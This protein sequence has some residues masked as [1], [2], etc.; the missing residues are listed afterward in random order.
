MIASGPIESITIDG[1][2][3]ATDGEDDVGIQLPGFT[4]EVKPNGDGTNRL[5]K[6]R[7]TGL[8]DGLNVQID[9]DREDLEFLQERQN[10]LEMLDVSCTT[11]S[12]VVYSGSM[13]IT[14]AIK[15]SKKEGTASI[16]LQG[17]IE[18]Q[19]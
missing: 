2:R 13:Q 10:S 12:G 11:V 5:V 6:A 19:G 8:I 14:E 4:N 9:D 15:V 18:K 3:F 7:S 17:V 1:R 16:T